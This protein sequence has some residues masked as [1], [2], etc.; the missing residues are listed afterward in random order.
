[1]ESYLHKLVSYFWNGEKEY[2]F[3]LDVS[4]TYSGHYAFNILSQSEKQVRILYTQ[5]SKLTL[6][7]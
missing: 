1:M 5:Y 6:E 7:E 4:K 2:G 3:V